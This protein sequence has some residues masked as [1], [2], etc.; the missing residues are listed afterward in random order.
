ME[1]IE[2]P[3]TPFEVYCYDCH[4]TF[5][6]GT[7]RCVHCGR[8]LERTRMQQQMLGKQ[9]EMQVSVPRWLQAG[10]WMGLW[11]LLMM[12]VALVRRCAGSEPSTSILLPIGVVALLM[13]A[14]GKA[15]R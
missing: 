12:V 7:R 1:L 10:I 5:P 6:V 11:M 13:L 8:R 4:V 15:G 3:Q 14:K 2:G 9:E